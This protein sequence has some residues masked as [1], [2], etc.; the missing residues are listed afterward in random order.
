[1]RILIFGFVAYVVESRGGHFADFQFGDIDRRI[2]RINSQ[3]SIRKV[4]NAKF[5]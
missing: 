5:R 3:R 1:M 2:V 4:L